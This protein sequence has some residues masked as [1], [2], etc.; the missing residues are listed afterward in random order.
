MGRRINLFSLANIIKDQ[1]G[2][3]N[4]SFVI[5]RRRES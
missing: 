3:L 2:D 5:G 4:E 1:G